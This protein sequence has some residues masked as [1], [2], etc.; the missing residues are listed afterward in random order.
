MRRKKRQR[1]ENPVPL[2]F[3]LWACS[4]S[5][6]IQ[7]Q[8]FS[9][10]QTKSLVFYRGEDIIQQLMRQLSKLQIY[11]ISS[12]LL[13][14][15]CYQDLNGTWIFEVHESTWIF[16]RGIWK[17]FIPFEKLKQQRPAFPWFSLRFLIW[18]SPESQIIQQL[19]TLP[20][21]ILRTPPTSKSIR[22]WWLFLLSFQQDQHLILLMLSNRNQS[23][24]LH[25]RLSMN[26]LLKVTFLVCLTL[27]HKNI[28]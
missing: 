27:S 6:N 23:F 20:L 16:Q 19:L 24:N 5:F 4:H 28:F 10:K 9:R 25:T 18:I 11:S 22:H 1:K 21:R 3:C 7:N 15:C 8:Y 26:S 13:H 14:F 2:P 17:T 12:P